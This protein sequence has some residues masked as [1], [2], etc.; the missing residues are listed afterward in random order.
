MRKIVYILI[1]CLLLLG[2]SKDDIK[3]PVNTV[4]DETQPN[5]VDVG[6]ALLAV[7][8]EAIDNAYVRKM[9]DHGNDFLYAFFPSSGD[10]Q[11]IELP[12]LRIYGENVR[13]DS[14][15]YVNSIMNEQLV[16]AKLNPSLFGE[17]SIDLSFDTSSFVNEYS[18]VNLHQLFLNSGYKE[19]NG[20]Y[21][22]HFDGYSLAFNVKGRAIT[23]YTDGT[24]YRYLSDSTGMKYGLYGG[25]CSYNLYD[26][27]VNNCVNGDVDEITSYYDSLVHP[28]LVKLG[29]HLYD[30]DLYYNAMLELKW[31][32]VRFFE[33][34][35]FPTFDASVY[36][37]DPES[38]SYFN[39]MLSYRG[40]T[41][42]DYYIS[43]GYGSTKAIFY[44]EDKTFSLADSDAVYNFG[45]DVGFYDGCSYD[46]ETGKGSCS[47][48]KVSEL[49]R[50]KNAM[51]AV[52]DRAHL[53][54]NELQLCFNVTGKYDKTIATEVGG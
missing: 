15:T 10:F 37:P 18:M 38:E 50:V 45:I 5:P 43:V 44:Y 3:K 39:L 30:L 9:Q 52:L 32:E 27:L 47:E 17:E 42:N 13:V 49:K 26:N 46:F 14:D 6:E 7:G 1:S 8:Y 51:Y 54:T 25:Y 28:E 36:T 12:T 22:K 53:N 20:F 41:F 23:L 34:N 40:A 48:A 35:R 2:C 24:Y 16:Q 29:L 33:P 21:E 19:E 11:M 31:D 4:I